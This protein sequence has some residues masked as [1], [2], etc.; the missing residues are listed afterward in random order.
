MTTVDRTR[1]AVLGASGHLGVAVVAA[2]G[3]LPVD[4]RLVGRDSARL[5]MFGH[6]WCSLNLDR[7]EAVAD[8]VQGC[9]VVV[10]LATDL[11]GAGSWRGVGGRAAAETVDTV[12]LRA[13]LDLADRPGARPRGLIYASTA[14]LNVP[15]GSTGRSGYEQ[16]K[17]TGEE[18]VLAGTTRGLICGSCLRLPTLYGVAAGDPA[19]NTGRGA[20]RALARQALDGG[21]VTVWGDGRNLRNLMHVEDAGTAFAAAVSHMDTL[22]GRAWDVGAATGIP[23]RELARHIV[24]RVAAVTGRDPVEVRFTEPPATSA[25]HDLADAAV[26]SGPFRQHTGWSPTRDLTR[27]LHHLISTLAAT[28]E[29][30]DLR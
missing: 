27:A 20:V 25:D 30:G 21:P 15:C 11:S 24:T 1:I 7:P 23:L 5:S 22:A 4:L 16:V 26:D 29:F 28:R 19:S 2:L 6:E 12:V 10:H 18:L 14:A 3:R 13:L 17:Q 8:A 9:S